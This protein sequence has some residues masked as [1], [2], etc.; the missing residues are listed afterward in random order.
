MDHGFIQG[1]TYA[2]PPSV[3]KPVPKK[4]ES[5]KF[6]FPRSLT[7]LLRWIEQTPKGAVP[8]LVYGGPEGIRRI[9]KRL[10]DKKSS[11][12]SLKINYDKYRS[13]WI[14]AYGEIRH[15]HYGTRNFSNLWK[16]AKWLRD[17]LQH[18]IDPVKKACFLWRAWSVGDPERSLVDSTYFKRLPRTESLSLFVASTC[19]RAVYFSTQHLH[20][21]SVAE[22]ESRWKGIYEKLEDGLDSRLRTYT[23]D[24]LTPLKRF[25]NSVTSASISLS[26]TVSSKACLEKSTKQGGCIAAIRDLH[27]RAQRCLFDLQDP[28]IIEPSLGLKRGDRGR[29]LP[30]Q[31]LEHL[32]RISVGSSRK[33]EGTSA[34]SAYR[35]ARFY[36]SRLAPAGKSVDPIVLLPNKLRRPLIKAIAIEELGQKVRVASLHPA[37]LAHFSRNFLERIMPL[38]KR[39]GATKKIL[40]NEPVRIKGSPGCKIYSADLTAASDFIDHNLGRSV[41]EGICDALDV[42][43]ITKSAVM[44]CIGPMELEN[45][46]T[47]RTGAHMG[48]G[49]TWS[50]LCILNHWCASN[51]GPQT[52]FSICGDDLVA[53]WTPHQVAI[54]ENSI[55]RV[56][57]VLNKAKSFYGESGVFCEQF[58]TIKRETQNYRLYESIALP[59]LAEITAA[60]GTISGDVC[61]E[62]QKLLS[63]SCLKPTRRTIELTL[64][65]KLKGKVAAPVQAGGYGGRSDDLIAASLL[66][67]Y[68]EKGPIRS[69]STPVPVTEV[70]SILAEHATKT[71]LKE[72]VRCDEAAITSLCQV[73]MAQVAN[74]ISTDTPKVNWKYHNYKGKARLSQGLRKLESRG[75]VSS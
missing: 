63:R 3:S 41:L 50:I 54:Y 26:K 16:F 22:A 24:I 39:L 21:K 10:I 9:E 19:S 56:G 37:A 59:R 11:L 31:N 20:A 72:S 2:L 13:A 30:R 43:P 33:L 40:R 7:D 1:R 23:R 38:L 71:P 4:S 28:T 67:Q 49:T 14:H 48:L 68:L 55:R 46:D 42:E 8:G 74:G 18:G 15:A 44:K 69:T 47:T 32:H 75:F 58:V 62:L 45:G 52:S 51:A 34:L 35:T 57:L 60:R 27:A 73:R 53:A 5:Q 12:Y 64:S 70:M 17:I 65:N 29:G 6:V 25:Q 66:L 36:T 61:T